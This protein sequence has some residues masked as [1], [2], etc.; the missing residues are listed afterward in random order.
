MLREC[1]RLQISI[2]WV[3]IKKNV[4]EF[5]SGFLQQVEGIFATAGGSIFCSWWFYDTMGDNAKYK[6]VVDL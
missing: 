4:F 5:V 6:H 3:K 2:V 1:K